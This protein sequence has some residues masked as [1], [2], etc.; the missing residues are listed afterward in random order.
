[1]PHGQGVKLLLAAKVSIEAAVRETGGRHD[2]A[3]RDLGKSS[4]IEQT[5]GGSNDP[6]PR[7]LFV[8]WRVRHRSIHH[9]S[10]KMILNIRYRSR[11]PTRSTRS[12]TAFTRLIV[13]PGG[14]SRRRP[15]G[16]RATSRHQ[17]RTSRTP[18]QTCVR[19]LT[20]SAN[21]RV[22]PFARNASRPRRKAPPCCQSVDRSRR[23]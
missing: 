3:D 20:P 1:M 5:G 21:A 7:L 12:L 6:L 2:L 15:P 14:R 4:P 8:P 16:V 11:E 18:D 19:L 10:E 13:R 9:T 22:P 23:A 17:P